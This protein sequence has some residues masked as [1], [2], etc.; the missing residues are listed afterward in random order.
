[1]Q[2]LHAESKVLQP[3]SDDIA[4]EAHEN[5]WPEF[6]LNNATVLNDSGQLISLLTANA[7]N[8]LILRGELGTLGKD[9]KHHCTAEPLFIYW[10]S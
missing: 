3:L 9:L 1:M 5:E 7:S 2:S 4:S 6:T 8:L 10:Q